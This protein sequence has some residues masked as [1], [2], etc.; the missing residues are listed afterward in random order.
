MLAGATAAA[1]GVFVR[2][3]DL[4][5]KKWRAAVIGHTGKGDY[6]HGMD[7]IFLGREDVEVVAVADVDEGGREKAIGRCGAK[8]AY[9][10]FREMLEKERPGL[11]SVAPRMTG[12]RKG[13]LLAA[14]SAGAHVVSEK[15]FVRAPVDGD[16]VLKLATEKRLR[17]AVAH[18]MRVA[19]T[20]MHLKKRIGEGLIG[21][22][23]EI[24]AF[25]KQDQRA[26]GEDM[27]VL[28]THL[29]DLMRLFAG[30]PL[31][32][33]ADVRQ[34]GREAKI[35][36]ART[37]GEDIG[38]IL[39]DEIVA[40]FALADGVVA[41]FTSRAKMREMTGHWGVELVGSKGAARILADISPRVM[42]RGAGKWEDS[43]RTDQWR[44][45]DDDPA[46]KMP[47]EQRTTAAQNGR[48]RDDWLA[49]IGAGRE[50]ACGGRNGAWAVE[51]VHGVWRAGL[52]G[53]RVPFPLR[54]RGHALG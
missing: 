19:P 40:Q 21:D 51:M 53:G 43:G 30:D 15:P 17:T 44:P 35:A 16:E 37:A 13:M 7:T 38:P 49:A 31:W 50:P 11:V 23:L 8:R 45:L 41:S 48:V 4:T 18:Q 22:L 26:G 20:V 5:G 9:A 27:V 3:D 14:L 39:G 47:P 54:E 25:G 12:E 46:L 34:G 2:G 42:V 32:C 6:G 29:F 36:D 24:R 1:M 10:D 33:S 52:S 28:G